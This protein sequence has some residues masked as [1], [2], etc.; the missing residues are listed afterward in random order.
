MYNQG[1]EEGL[2]FLIGL[3]LVILF[4]VPIGIWA[5]TIYVQENKLQYSVDSIAQNIS[6]LNG[7][8]KKSLLTYTGKPGEFTIIGFDA[9]DKDF[10]AE[11][12]WDCTYHST[13]LAFLGQIK[14]P[15]Q[16][17]NKACICSC[18]VSATTFKDACKSSSAVCSTIDIDYPL[19]FGGKESECEYG[20]FV[21][22][23]NE[24]AEIKMQRLGNLVGVCLYSD[25]L[26]LSQVKAAEVY[27]KFVENYRQCISSSIDKCLCGAF[28]ASSLPE[29]YKIRIASSNGVTKIGLLSEEKRL[30]TTNFEDNYLCEYLGMDDTRDIPLLEFS[31]GEPTDYA[32]G[33]L[34][35]FYKKA[36]QVTCVTG[37]KDDSFNYLLQSQQ[38]SNNAEISEDDSVALIVSLV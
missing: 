35:N 4:L 6:K 18:P 33:N 10:G 7:N 30:A 38:C 12:F 3:I 23:P 26:D 27:D 28:D 31:K 24:I 32:D 21:N 25:C 36:R 14:K 9:G 1:A 19:K 16:C 11:G 17:G 5:Y 20:P 37:K 29:G 2:S 13:A 22:N 34:I 15:A 8:E